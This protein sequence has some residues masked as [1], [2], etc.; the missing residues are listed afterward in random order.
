MDRRSISSDNDR[1]VYISNIPY[2]IRW[3]ELK[4]IIRERAGEVAFVEMLENVGGRSKGC[5]FDAFHLRPLEGEG[6]GVLDCRVVEFKDSEGARKCVSNL[7]RI[8]LRDR[9]LVAKEIRDPVAFFRK[10]KEDMGVD[11]FANNSAE[12]NTFGT[13]LAILLLALLEGKV[14]EGG[15]GV[16][17][18]DRG[19]DRGPGG[20]FGRER[21]RGPP[22]QLDNGGTFD[23]FGLSPSFLRQ[24]GIEG[25][26]CNRVFVANLPFN[27]Q[28]GRIMD[29]FNLAGQVRQG[30]LHQFQPPNRQAGPTL[31]FDE[32]GWRE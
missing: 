32:L 28:S 4:D 20:G 10:V 27:M 16:G 7:N 5:A 31:H 2:D 15:G 19:G 22:G 11:F 21:G 14:D 29:V 30:P 12:S 23:T 13:L 3:M 6:K 26:L 1:M 17:R 9:Y 25:P 24:L 18:R 8:Q